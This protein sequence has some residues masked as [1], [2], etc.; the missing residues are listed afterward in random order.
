MYRGGWDAGA[1]QC[2]EGAFPPGG[3]VTRSALK[4]RKKSSVGYH[5]YQ[6]FSGMVDGLWCC[7]LCKRIGGRTWKNEKDILDHVWNTHCNTPP[8]R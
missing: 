3:V 6:E 8:T 2:L 5:D 1:T 7:R 4:V